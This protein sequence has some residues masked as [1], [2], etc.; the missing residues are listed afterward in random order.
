MA[1]RSLSRWPVRAVPAGAAAVRDALRAEQ[2]PETR[3]TME[4][5]L[6]AWNAGMMP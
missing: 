4:Q 2:E 5:L 6:N 1:I 3:E